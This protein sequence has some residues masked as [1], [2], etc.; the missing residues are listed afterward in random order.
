MGLIEDELAEIK[1]LC[2]HVIKGSRLVSCV[3]TMVR[4]EIKES[5]FRKII[6]CMQFPDKYPSNPLLIELKSKTL[7][8]RLLYGLTNIC[9]KE[10]TKYLGKPQVMIILQFIKNFLVEN[11][12]SCC[13]D[14]INKVKTK[15]NLNQDELK[16]K[17]KQ[18]AITLKMVSGNYYLN[19]KIFVPS[20]Y[21]LSCVK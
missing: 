21:P 13:Y 4:V 20:D 12:L 14:E 1:K 18:S 2:E 9:E 10:A 3:R 15:L 19:T 8:E 6:I 16:L 17:Q 5:E 11:P 7:S